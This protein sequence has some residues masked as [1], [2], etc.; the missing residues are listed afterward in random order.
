MMNL[1][2]VAPMLMAIAILVRPSGIFADDSIARVGAGGITFLKS[3]EIR[4]LEEVLEISAKKIR[5]KFR[6]LNESA[7]DILTTVAFPLP[8]GD[9]D[10]HPESSDSYG[11]IEN[12]FRVWAN[13]RTVLP[14]TNRR[15]IIGDRDVTEKLRK[16]GLS[17][18]Q[19]FS[20]CNSSEQLDRDLSENRQAALE[21]VVG[22]K[23]QRN[24]CNVGLTLFW[25][26]RFPA[27]EAIVIEHE[28]APIVGGSY[29][30]SYEK[31]GDNDSDTLDSFFPGGTERVCLDDPTSRE[32]EHRIKDWASK[33]PGMVYMRLTDVE[34]IL[35]TGRNWKGPIGKFRLRIE[36]ETPEQI[37]S[38]CFPGKPKK[39]SPTVY[40]F[41][42]KDYVP[43]DKLVVYFFDVRQ[44]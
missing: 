12:T 15:L 14:L 32:I 33:S 26:Q 23:E 44:E 19:I 36:K 5:V 24:P 17:D 27:R 4:M 40:E 16:I 22:R 10:Y 2:K 6:F 38:L 9:W 1:A 29:H 20:F 18:K 43:Q 42:Q 13:G 28:Y 37:V 31:S 21:K 41:V 35:S 39:V 11:Q 30:G 25:K 3:K 7:K 8:L 34:Y